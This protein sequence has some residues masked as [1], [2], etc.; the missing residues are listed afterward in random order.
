MPCPN[1]NPERTA[2][3]K[4]WSIPT[5]ASC[6]VS[7][8]VDNRRL[9]TRTNGKSKIDLE[10]P[11]ETGLTYPINMQSSM[12]NNTAPVASLAT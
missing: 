9:A 4:S 3:F 10:L 7:R 2:T 11:R 1:P 6:T 12:P 5:N 8:Q